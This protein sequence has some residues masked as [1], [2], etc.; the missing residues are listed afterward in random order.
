M[1]DILLRTPFLA[2]RVLLLKH[3]VSSGLMALFDWLTASKSSRRHENS[4]NIAMVNDPSSTPEARLRYR[5]CATL[6]LVY[7]LEAER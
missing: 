2:L 3:G 5:S 4:R 6:R 1:A 7:L